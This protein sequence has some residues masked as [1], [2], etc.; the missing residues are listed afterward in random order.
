MIVNHAILITILALF[1]PRHLVTAADRFICNIDRLLIMRTLPDGFFGEFFGDNQEDWG[2]HSAFLKLGPGT[3]HTGIQRFADHWT[4]QAVNGGACEPPDDTQHE[5]GFYT[6][7]FKYGN[8]RNGAEWCHDV[9]SSNVM[10]YELSIRAG[11]MDS[12]F[13]ITSYDNGP[14][15]SEVNWDLPQDETSYTAEGPEGRKGRIYVDCVEESGSCQDIGYMYEGSLGCDTL[16]N[17]TITAQCIDQSAVSHTAMV[18]SGMLEKVTYEAANVGDT[19]F[20]QYNVPANYESVCQTDGAG[21][22]ELLSFEADCEDTTS[23][24]KEKLMVSGRPMCY[25]IDCAS[26]SDHNLLLQKYTLHPTEMLADGAYGGNWICTSTGFLPDGESACDRE[27]SALS[28]IGGIAATDKG[29]AATVTGKMFLG[30]LAQEGNIVTFDDNAKIES[31]KAAC[32]TV[33]ATFSEA[34]LK[35]ECVGPGVDDKLTKF[36]V[37]KFPICL[38]VTCKGDNK[39][40]FNLGPLAEK[41][42]AADKL[43]SNYVCSAV[44]SSA[45]TLA[46]CSIVVCA[47]VAG[48]TSFM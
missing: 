32:R 24:E 23:G 19:I 30:I 31:Y 42:Q 1:L 13:G 33:G 45:E 22:F 15:W 18:E 25:G 9:G 40:K 38:G 11:N 5:D 3:R 16:C 44:T 37:E 12:V 14:T 36:D 28:V 7:L 26:A 35:V 10:Y 39:L 6:C 2:V 48:V 34:D 8:S 43:E 47:I 27:S 17:D 20:Y 46:K 29:I 21:R 41:L 4:L